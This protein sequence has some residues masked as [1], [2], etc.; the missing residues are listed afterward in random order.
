MDRLTLKGMV[1]LPGSA[2]WTAN[3][4]KKKAKTDQ[5]AVGT[6]WKPP[7]PPPGRPHRGL[8][9]PNAA[10]GHSRAKAVHISAAR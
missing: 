4:V 9:P 6:A 1:N 10:K 8:T 3:P 2:A 5:K 7:M